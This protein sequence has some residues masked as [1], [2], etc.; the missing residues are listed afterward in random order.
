MSTAI[1]K[2]LLLL[3]GELRG[4]MKGIRDLLESNQQSTNTRIEDLTKV[5]DTRL[6]AS[7]ERI[8]RLEEGERSLIWKVG[9][10]GTTAG[11]VSAM[12]VEIGKHY[13]GK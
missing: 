11:A 12:L 9:G 2:D 6:G 7:E 4:D 13:L 8:S 5:V 1:D 10:I 3:L